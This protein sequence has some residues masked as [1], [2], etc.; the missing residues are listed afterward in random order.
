MSLA[1]RWRHVKDWAFYLRHGGMEYSA[2]C[3]ECNAGYASG[4]CWW[5]DADHFDR[6][7][8]TPVTPDE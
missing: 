7:G 2:P 4:L 6:L 1:L 3:L 8:H 5:Y